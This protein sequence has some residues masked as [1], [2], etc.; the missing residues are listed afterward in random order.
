MPF[1]E[2]DS[3]SAASLASLI[4]LVADRASNR[5]SHH[6]RICIFLGAGADI[7]AGGL[8]FSQLKRQ[9][10]EE[11]ARRPLF[12]ITDES[13]IDAQFDSLF[14]KLPPDERALLV[15]ALFRRLRPLRPSD[16]YKLLVLLAE[17]G[18]IDAVVTTN[19][20]GMLEAAQQELG[21]DTFQV[22]APGVARPYLMPD[23]GFSSPRAPYLKLHG[24][25]S[26]HAV[27]L[28]TAADLE[29]GSYDTS[30]LQLLEDI[31]GSHDLIIAG[32]SGNDAVLAYLI[33]K[34]VHDK[35]TRIFWAT[36]GELSHASP[37]ARLLENRARQVRATFDDLVSDLARPVLERPSAAISQP[38][39]M[40][41]LFD[42]RI[43]YGNRE[44][45]NA[46][47]SRGGVSIVDL[48]ARRNVIE[49]QL[50]QFLQSQRRLA[51]VSGPSGYG[52]TT[53][54]VRLHR[55]WNGHRSTRVFLVRS[56]T[57]PADGDIEQLISEQLGG[58]GSRTPF[59]IFQLERWAADN[60]VRIVLFIDGLN[61]FSPEID[62]CVHVFRS[63]LRYCYFLPEAESALRIILTIRQETWRAMLPHI[64]TMLLRAVLWAPDAADQAPHT[65]ACDK[66]TA[67]ELEDAI[68]RARNAKYAAI[69][70]EALSSDA[71]EIVR[72]PYAFGL[73]ADAV[74]RGG[75][76]TANLYKTLYES[77]LAL[78]GTYVDRATILDSLCTVALGCLAS[79]EDRFREVD[80][81]PAALRGE[82]V[83]SMK[84]LRILV[85]ATGGFLR[86]DHDR[87]LEYF[88]AVGLASSTKPSLET[89]PDLLHFLQRFFT[90]GRAIAA[91]RLHYQLAP[92]RFAGVMQAMC[93]LD[94]SGPFTRPEAEVLFGFARDVLFEMSEQNEVVAHRYLEDA[95]HAART[96][97]IGEHQER[98]VVQCIAGLTET[99]AIPLLTVASHSVSSVARTEAAVYATDRLVR[100][101]LTDTR[102]VTPIDL[103]RRQPYAT[104]LAETD[105]PPWRRLGRLLGFVAELGPDN[106][107][108]NEYAEVAQSA[109]RALDEI[110]AEPAWDHA[111]IAAAEDHLLANLDRLLF[112]AT[113]AGV[114]RFFASHRR[115][116]FADII[117][118][119]GAGSVL[120]E[121]DWEAVAQFT[122]SLEYDVEYHLCHVLLLTSA[123]N[124]L[125]STI[126][127]VE[128]HLVGLTDRSSPVEIDFWH[129]ALVYLHVACALPYSENRFAKYEERILREWPHILLFRPGLER[130]ER[131]GFDDPFD[132]NFEDGFAV[133]F[134]YGMLK[135]GLLRRRHTYEAY[136][137]E[138]DASSA[139][140]LPLYS[141]YLDA[142]IRAGR[143]EETIQLLQTLAMVIT[144]WPM[145]GLLAMR[146][147]IGLDEPRLR[148]AVLRV[149]A[150]AYGRHPKETTH[151][152]RTSGVALSDEDFREIKIRRD[153][154]LGR[155][156]TA[157]EQW[158]RVAHFLLA[159][160]GG[161]ASL[162]AVVEA[163]VA[164]SSPREAMQSV[165]REVGLLIV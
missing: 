105:E 51:V 10:I 118:R 106:T 125:E 52:K 76:A 42:W 65:I 7:S 109:H 45:L 98:A 74:H 57:L 163:I 86:F 54:G 101:F 49:P 4:R 113:V 158:G 27:T 60:D 80:V 131:R 146:S 104:F 37:L 91:A 67:D 99:K 34:F 13:I 12:D 53:I 87:T 145:E 110:L 94:A 28:L 20:D 73:V 100:R 149:L 90:Q 112:N 68:A 133:I 23:G 96:G 155:R 97:K 127:F 6:R 83:R 164:A 26:S 126:Q 150:E 22:F 88:L 75:T 156:Q 30:M 38:T 84:D 31:L 92:D 95:V 61:E 132:R 9:A 157:E 79:G 137:R 107:H 147:A 15:E 162:V 161:K 102:A 135:P 63:I 39:Y 111:S 59:S 25:L 44:Y 36:V 81:R 152:L 148:R 35:A 72:D 115:H 69:D 19:F 143:I 40:K 130:G 141:H 124:N 3:D 48:F 153:A 50:G 151:F 16:A 123:L 121:G 66:F 2:V 64:D 71:A 58:L 46:Y 165:L 77:R 14:T 142:F 56:R 89:L 85:D 62:R 122:Q 21:R 11:F 32:Y 129:S 116:V 18:A 17:A 55:I 103:S 114:E 1:S 47:A 108:P 140:P 33:A 119:L 160:K 128:T 154:R 138:I 41:C 120:S 134:P 159:R 78:H 93:L 139:S 136:R 43:E 5:R 70:L 8:S 117:K 144:A 82:I 29:S 24:D